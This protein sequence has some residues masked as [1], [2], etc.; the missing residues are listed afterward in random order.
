MGMNNDV[1]Q[2][3][4][5]AGGKAESQRMKRGFECASLHLI[6]RTCSSGRRSV[7]AY[8]GCQML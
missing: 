4:Q 5:V 3:C 8:A 2:S 7:L 6:Q 1:A